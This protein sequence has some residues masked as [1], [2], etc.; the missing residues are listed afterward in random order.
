MIDWF[1]FDWMIAWLIS[2]QA[3]FLDDLGPNVKAARKLG[4]A[5]ILVRD[6]NKALEELQQITGINVSQNQ[7]ASSWNT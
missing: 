4:M 5:T 6:F 2:I 7:H 1:N 3:V